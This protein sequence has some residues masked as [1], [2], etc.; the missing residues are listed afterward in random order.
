MLMQD[1]AQIFISVCSQH[2]SPDLLRWPLGFRL[3]MGHKHILVAA[4]P[5]GC[6]K[7]NT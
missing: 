4:L 3:H 2:T 1:A 5:A 6:D 7:G